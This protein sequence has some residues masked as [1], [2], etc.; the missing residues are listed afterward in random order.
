LF[1]LVTCAFGAGVATG[2]NL[3]TSH[4][5]TN[6]P[7]NAIAH[8]AGTVYVGGDFQQVWA[9]VP[10]GSGG[11]FIGGS[12]NRVGGVERFG[13]AHILS[14]NT[15]SSW[16]PNMQGGTVTSL[17]LNGATIFVGGVLSGS[18]QGSRTSVLPTRRR[19]P[20]AGFS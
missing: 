13:L 9:V 1:T 6:G 20:R 8:S 10:D 4:W 16:D 17:V 19:L 2:Q 18:R 14:D 3:N 5:I 15:V 11:W 12:F 7:V